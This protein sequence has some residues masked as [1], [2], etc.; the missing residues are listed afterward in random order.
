MHEI[1]AISCLDLP[2]SDYESVRIINLCH[3]M[4]IHRIYILYTTFE[5]GKVYLDCCRVSMT[6][7]TQ[8]H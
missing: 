4:T 7:L 3:K 2:V 6:M 5:D 8:M 1:L